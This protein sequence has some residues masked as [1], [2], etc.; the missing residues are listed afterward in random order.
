[1]IDAD[2]GARE[3]VVPIQIGSG[4]AVIFVGI[5]GTNPAGYVPLTVSVQ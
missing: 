4:D 2:G 1:M 3:I 5:A